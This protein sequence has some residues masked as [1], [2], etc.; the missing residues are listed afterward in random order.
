MQH[1]SF[2]SAEGR[3][4]VIDSILDEQTCQQAIEL[5]DD[6]DDWT[7]AQV[8]DNGS[9]YLVMPTIRRQKIIEK[10]DADEVVSALLDKVE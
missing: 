5:L 6:S 1:S 3:Y 7:I 10:E 8:T 9:S 2:Y 4:R